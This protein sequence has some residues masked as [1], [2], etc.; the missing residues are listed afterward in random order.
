MRHQIAKALLAKAAEAWVVGSIVEPMVV[1]RH[2]PESHSIAPPTL[3]HR[4]P[5]PT[6]QDFESTLR[7]NK[8]VKGGFRVG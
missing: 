2:P 5:S 3:T 8:G 7:G 1:E 6:F 4:N